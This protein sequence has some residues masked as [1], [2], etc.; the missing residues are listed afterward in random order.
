M[1]GPEKIDYSLEVAPHD[2]EFYLVVKSAAEAHRAGGTTYQKFTCNRCNKRLTVDEPN[3]FYKVGRCD[4]CGN[5]DI[6]I[7]AQGCNFIVVFDGRYGRD[8][9]D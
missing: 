3:V 2:H 7:V 8:P 1:Q 4:E 9:R 5:D 6:D